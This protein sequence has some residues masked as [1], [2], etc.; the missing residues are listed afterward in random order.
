MNW[1][2]GKE[3]EVWRILQVYSILGKKEVKTKPHTILD[4]FSE[5]ELL[6]SAY[7]NE[8]LDPKIISIPG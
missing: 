2:R 5:Y 7:G 6:L 8:G 1:F 3:K 4:D